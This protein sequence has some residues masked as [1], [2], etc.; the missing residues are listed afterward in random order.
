M[1]TDDIEFLEGGSYLSFATLKK[2]GDYV[3][4]PVWFGPGDGSYYIFSAGDAGKVKRLR[5]FSQCRVA[6]CTATGKLTGDW[7]EG[8]AYL[9]EEDDDIDAALAALHRR[10]G[11]QMKMTDFLSRLSGKMG[12]RSY[13]RVDPTTD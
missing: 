3:A 9:L 6:A 13:I 8:N 11:W 2:S 10:Y 4:T 12:K 5:N 7:I 1:S